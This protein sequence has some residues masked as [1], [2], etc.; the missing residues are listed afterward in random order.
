MK[1]IYITLSLFVLILLP[2]R[3]VVGEERLEVFQ[4]TTVSSSPNPVGSGARAMGMGGAFIAVADDATAASWNPAGLTQLR[5]PEISIVYSH[6]SRS[7]DLDLSNHPESSASPSVSSDD[8]N[9][10]SIVYP[11]TLCQRNMTVSLNYQLLYEFKNNINFNYNEVF[12]GQQWKKTFDIKQ[13]GQLRTLSP[14]Y[15]IQVTPRLSLGIT[16]NFWTDNLF[17]SN[18]WTTEKTETAKTYGRFPLLGIE[19]KWLQERYTDF[20]GFN[21]NFGFLWN[22]NKFL[23]LGA[24]LKTP[25]TAHVNYKSA[26]NSSTFSFPPLVLTKPLVTKTR[27]NVDLNMPLSYGFG[28]ACRFSDAFTMSLDIY[29]TD[30]SNYI[31]E[32]SKGQ[33]YSLIT[34]E[35][36]RDSHV[37]DTTQVHLGGEYLFILTNTVIPVRGGLFYDPEPAEGHPQDFWGFSLGSGIS[38]KNIILDCAYQYRHGNNAGKQNLTGFP[39][40]K[41]DV[42][43]HLFLASVIYHF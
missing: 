17:W 21:M 10:L 6:F 26:N 19:N 18:G 31:L 42:T 1:P 9:Y 11:F 29:V 3:E 37:K 32:T 22:I 25:F 2:C 16:F 28:V 33:R 20:S 13:D 43:Q 36:S 30:W 39:D 7:E 12:L 41:A 8:L 5:K 35:S 34:A 23:T 27:D 24:V 14:A 40:A 38:I 4:H 15:A